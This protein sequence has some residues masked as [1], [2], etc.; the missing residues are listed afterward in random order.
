MVKIPFKT[1]VK[2]PV[3]KIPLQTAVKFPV[4]KIPFAKNVFGEKFRAQIFH[5]Q[6]SSNPLRVG[7]IPFAVQMITNEAIPSLPEAGLLLSGLFANIE[8]RCSNF[9]I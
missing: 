6:I 8:N 3:V 2:F 7:S 4:V 5:D 9:F 1:A